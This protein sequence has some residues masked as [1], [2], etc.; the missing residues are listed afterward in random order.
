MPED[1][2]WHFIGHLQSNKVK[3]VLVPNLYMIETIDSLKYVKE[4]TFWLA[5][6]TLC[7]SDS[8]ILSKKLVWSW[9][10][11]FECSCKSKQAKKSV[12]LNKISYL[13]QR[14]TY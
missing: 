13:I 5:H 6:W 8:L 1:V 14:F 3:M 9:I 7:V 12:S 2:K 10:E 4:S 11:I